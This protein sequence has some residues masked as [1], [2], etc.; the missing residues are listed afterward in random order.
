MLHLRAIA[1]LTCKIS[2]SATDVTCLTLINLLMQHFYWSFNH[3]DLSQTA[4]WQIVLLVAVLMLASKSF[5]GP[6]RLKYFLIPLSALPEDTRREIGDVFSTLSFSSQTSS[7]E[8]VPTVSM[9][10][11]MTRHE[12]LN[13]CVRLRSGRFSPYIIALVIG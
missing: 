7:R 11:G 5:V 13:P 6:P 4:I 12:E 2:S 1:I 10:F 3:H 9:V 8:I